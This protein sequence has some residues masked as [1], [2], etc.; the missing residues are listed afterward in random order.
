MAWFLASRGF[1]FNM[2]FL[3]RRVCK[4]DVKETRQSVGVLAVLIYII[5]P[6]C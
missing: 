4:A 3:V 6:M 1:K 5:K 2:R